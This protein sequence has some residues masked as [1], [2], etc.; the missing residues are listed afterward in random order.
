MAETPKLRHEDDSRTSRLLLNEGPGRSGASR[1]IEGKSRAEKLRSG[2]SV[3]L[4]HRARKMGEEELD[5]RTRAAMSKMSRRD[6]VA[7]AREIE[8]LAGEADEGDEAGRDAVRRASAAFSVGKRLA[9]QGVAAET[10]AEKN[11]VR[12]AS[13]GREGGQAHV[14]DSR[15]G[16]GAKPVG[17]SGYGTSSDKDARPSSRLTYADEIGMGTNSATRAQEKGRHGALRKIKAREALKK[18]RKV[19]MIASVRK[20]EAARTAA[21]GAR[22]ARKARVASFA[23]KGVG[24]LSIAALPVILACALFLIMVIGLVT[25]ADEA[26][27]HPEAVNE[28]LPEACE[29]WRPVVNEACTAILGDTKW[30]DLALAMMAQESGGSLDVTCYPGGVKRQDIMQACEGAYGSWIIV[31]GGPYNLAPC[32]PRASIYAGVAELK[33]NLDLWSGYLG[34]IEPWEIDKVKLVVQ[35]YNYGARGYYNWNVRH[36]YKEWTL[37]RSRTYSQ[38]VMPAGAKGTPEHADYV[39]RYY[40]YSAGEGE[41]V[42]A[43]VIAAAKSQL[44]VP[45][46]WGGTS[47]FVGLDCSGLTQYCYRQAGIEIT[48]TTY[49]QVAAALKKVPVFQARPGDVLWNSHHV[50]IYVGDG[51][52]IHAPHTGDVVRYGSALSTFTYALQFY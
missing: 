3:R 13:K 27:E 34:G 28:L 8:S 19:Q 42:G 22:A 11:N 20:A 50:A 44:G 4:R 49:T 43:A 33:Q 45:Y 18:R 46:V 12:A 40:T 2:S 41:G 32:T 48:R 17:N 31:G 24:G 14:T 30:A 6:K 1:L 29:I 38:T 16:F 35:G 10:E 36:G 21:K 23:A 7:I 5:E 15:R 47:P 51:Q 37:E 39:M 25:V 9:M 26:T 52:Y